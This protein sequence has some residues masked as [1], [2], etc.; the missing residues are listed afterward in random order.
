MPTWEYKAP[1]VPQLFN[2]PKG[3]KMQAPLAVRITVEVKD[4]EGAVCYA[5]DHTWSGL[6]VAS[7][8]E[9]LAALHDAVFQHGRAK[10]AAGKSKPA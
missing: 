1:Q 5:A 8:V 4:A 10:V 3:I 9:F 6:S 7:E 2:Q